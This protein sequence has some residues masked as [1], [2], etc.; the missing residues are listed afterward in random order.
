MYVLT[1]SKNL[2]VSD[3]IGSIARS[4]GLDVVARTGDEAIAKAEIAKPAIIVVDLEG[5]QG[6][7]EKL[8]I[9]GISSL[10]LGFYPHMKAEI[11]RSA[12]NLGYTN[13]FPNSMM[14]VKVKEFLEKLT[15]A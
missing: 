5:S 1:V 7:L 6:F 10:V 11:K 13:I 8:K 12:E 2:I 9:S 14:E 4:Y 3:K 15:N